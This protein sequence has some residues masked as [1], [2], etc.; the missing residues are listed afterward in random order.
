VGQ[1]IRHS[2]DEA[3]RL[4][5]AAAER[6]FREGGYGAVRV[7]LVARDVGMTDAAV[8]YHFG[9]R[10]GLL[11]ALLRQA[12]RGVRAEVEAAVRG[13]SEGSRDLASLAALF[14]DCYD[15]RGYARLAMWLNLAGVRGGRGSG[16]LSALVDA[17]RRSSEVAAR[18]QGLTAPT[19]IEIQFVV[20]LFHTVE[21][22]EPLFGEAMRRSAGLPGDEASRERYRTW[23]L[24]VFADVLQA[25]DTSSTG[26][27]AAN[28][29]K[30]GSLGTTKRRGSP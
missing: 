4:I 19:P 26:M 17:L 20:A 24:G 29:G 16:M 25:K 12:G 11:T 13:W 9:N 30:S 5:L 8:H 6:R 23:L 10:Q 28:V 3:K 14:A 2:A 21:V 18:E 27:K 7:Q 22:A 15:R 1:R